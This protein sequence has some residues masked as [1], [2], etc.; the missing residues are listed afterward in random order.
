MTTVSSNTNMVGFVLHAMMMA[1]SVSEEVRFNATATATKGDRR[2]I[3][4]LHIH[5][6]G[7]STMASALWL[8]RIESFFRVNPV[9]M[10]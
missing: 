6:A 9:F 1:V 3:Y 10:H 5:K 7:G 8:S 2:I 4:F